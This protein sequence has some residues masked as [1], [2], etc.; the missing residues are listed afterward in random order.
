M[1]I[2]RREGRSIQRYAHLGTGNYHA[3]NA[4]LYTDYSL[5]T[6]D[7][8]MT[9]D[10]RKIFQQL[11]GMG[12]AFRIKK[13]LHA[14]FTL[15]KGL[16]D[17]I[18]REAGNAKEGKPARIIMKMN[19]LTEKQMIRALYKASQAGV[20]IDLVVRGICCLRPGIEGLSENIQVRSIIGRL[21]EHSRVYCFENDGEQLVYCSSAD[22]MSRNLNSRV[23]T[24]FPIEEPKMAARVMKEL[25]LYLNDNVR[26]WILKSDGSYEQNKPA[27]GQRRRNVQ[28]KL[29]ET[30]ANYST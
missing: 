28:R 30:L 8:D 24:C 5:L 4:R 16:I 23:E 21:L 12:K 17:L 26:S 15:K 20:K 3:G 10:V 27:R 11:T 29:L 1:L 13:L 19:A 18:N 22:G 9:N 7:K 6:C 25:E 14:P 2:V